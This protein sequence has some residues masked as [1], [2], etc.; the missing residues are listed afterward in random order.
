MKVVKY[1]EGEKIFSRTFPSPEPLDAFSRVVS[2]LNKLGF[3]FETGFNLKKKY[4]WIVV[5]T[6]D[7]CLQFHY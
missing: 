4:F 3:F 7:N 5:G 2:R 6:G 1:K